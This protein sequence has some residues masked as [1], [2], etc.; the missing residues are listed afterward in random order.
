MRGGRRMFALVDGIGNT[1]CD[2]D[3]LVVCG[4]DESEGYGVS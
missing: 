1:F 2:G 4:Q 3:G